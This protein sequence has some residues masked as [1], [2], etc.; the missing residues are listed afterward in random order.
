MKYH[1]NTT[2]KKARVTGYIS[3]RKSRFHLRNIIRDKQDPFKMI[4]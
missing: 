2:Q 1:A 3:V 4:K